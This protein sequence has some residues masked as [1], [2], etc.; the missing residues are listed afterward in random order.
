[1][2]IPIWSSKGLT[3]TWQSQVPNLVESDLTGSPT[4][5]LTGTLV[6]HLA[7]P[8]E[9]WVI[10]Y[11]K[12]AYVPIENQYNARAAHL[13]PD[14]KLTFSAN[15]AGMRR[16]DL[17]GF[18]TGLRRTTVIDQKRNN[19]RVI[20]EKVD[21]KPLGRDADEIFRTLTFYNRAGG[22]SYTTLDNNDLRTLD[23]SSQLDLNRAVLFGK[24]AAKAA[25]VEVNGETTEPASIEAYVRIV[26]PV[27]DASSAYGKKL[28]DRTP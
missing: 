3:A 28:S 12:M 6:H 7:G 13:R 19:E 5:G 8:L 9:D 1:L 23:L 2:P 11:G 17:N 27:K 25:D 10:A 15:A 14:R 20:V 18:L 26:L 24:I 22:K 4:G 21:Y 16:R